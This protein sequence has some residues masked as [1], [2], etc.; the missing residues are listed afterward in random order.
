MN[1]SFHPAQAKVYQSNKRF[2]V[3]C[4]GRRFG[5]TFYSI[6]E[7]LFFALNNPGSKIV[8]FAPTRQ[9]A[10]DIVWGDLKERTLDFI[11]KEP[12][13]TRL[14]IMLKSKA[15]YNKRTGITHLSDENPSEIWL[16]G[17]EN[18]ESARGNGIDLLI[19]DEVASTRNWWY[20][21]NQILRP[22]LTDTKGK[23]IFISTPK[24]FNHFWDLYNKHLDDED[25]ASFHFTSYDNP[26]LDPGEIDKARKEISDDYF[27]QEYLAEFVSVSGQVYKSWDMH[28]QFIPLEYNP[29]LELHVSFDFG[30]NDPTA[31]IWF[32]RNGPE[33][34][35]IDYYE[36]KNASIEHF[37][38]V[39]NSKPYKKP[40]LY[41]GDPAGRA[42]NHVT[43]T[44][45]IQEYGKNGIHIRTIPNVKIEEQIRI[46]HKYIIGLFV[47]DKLTR[48]RDCI[49]NYRYPDRENF[50][51]TSNEDPVHDEYSHF[52]RAM[53][54]YFTNIDQGTANSSK[55]FQITQ[56]LFKG[57]NLE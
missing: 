1:L 28:R 8:Y 19:A 41:T 46:T 47:S 16:R 17:I 49:L 7:M 42:R 25:Y 21:W 10:R 6:S 37:I 44:S 12:N 26:Y 56:N 4:A 43:N 54:Y 30:V 50:M 2:K 31:I 48:V 38:Q 13:E 57:W 5:K 24:G 27:K 52:N 39:L 29:D 20:A 23:A 36:E 51:N 14:E 53:E 32:Q 9:Q 11:I 40:T 55:L 3:I 18:I 34:N 45:I 22:T 15:G 35:I 33:F